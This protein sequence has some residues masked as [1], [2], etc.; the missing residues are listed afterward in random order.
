ME[1]VSDDLVTRLRKL[2]LACDAVP[3]D[4][5]TSAT[6]ALAC[7]PLYMVA[8]VHAWTSDRQMKVPLLD[9]PGF[10]AIRESFVIGAEEGR[11]EM[12]REHRRVLGTLLTSAKPPDRVIYEYA[13][14]S[15]RRFLATA[16]PAVAEQ[17]RVAVARMVVHIAEASGEGIFG[18][19]EKVSPEERACI[20]QIDAAL[21]LRSSPA[22][23]EALRGIEAA[24]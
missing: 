24:P 15:L 17:V 11:V 8:N 21:S 6:T 13:L 7:F 12:S 2:G 4:R 10:E 1:P 3:A 14:E 20:E 19:G 18:T 16:S 9:W 22:A 5:L 23:A